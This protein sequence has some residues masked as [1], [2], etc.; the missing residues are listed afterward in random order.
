MVAQIVSISARYRT[1]FKLMLAEWN[2]PN[3]QRFSSCGACY[4]M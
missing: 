1:K 4:R 3:N 2:W